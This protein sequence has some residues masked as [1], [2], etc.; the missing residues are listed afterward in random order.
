MCV[1]STMNFTHSRVHKG[2]IQS[3]WG[4]GY[5]NGRG[6]SINYWHRNFHTQDCTVSDTLPYILNNITTL[7]THFNI[8][9]LTGTMSAKSTFIFFDYLHTLMCNLYSLNCNFYTLRCKFYS[10]ECKFYIFIRIMYISF[11]RIYIF[12]CI[13][14]TLKCKVFK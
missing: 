10:F 13:I 14:Y 11:C 9:R 12:K 6:L 8:L 2:R 4:R 7:T 5:E 3:W 1:S